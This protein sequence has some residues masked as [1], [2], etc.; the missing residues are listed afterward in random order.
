MERE[1]RKGKETMATD[2]VLETTLV[3]CVLVLPQP[4][5]PLCFPAENTRLDAYR[6]ATEG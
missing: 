3:S 5:N 4:T 6:R 2:V 1:K